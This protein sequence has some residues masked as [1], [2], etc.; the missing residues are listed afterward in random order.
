MHRINIRRQPPKAQRRRHDIDHQPLRRRRRQSPVA[1]RQRK[2][3]TVRCTGDRQ[4]RKT[5]PPRVPALDSAARQHHIPRRR[6][7]TRA[8][9]IVVRIPHPQ[10]IPRL[11]HRLRRKFPTIHHIPTHRTRVRRQHRKHNPLRHYIQSQRFQNSGGARL[12]PGPQ[13]ERL[14]VPRASDRQIRKRDPTAIP[15]PCG[16]SRQ[17]DIPRFNT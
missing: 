6:A 5:Q 3:L 7:Q 9:R 2:H 4:S 13:N 14:P 16:R 12:V 8:A 17:L 10:P 11:Q 15:F 1:G